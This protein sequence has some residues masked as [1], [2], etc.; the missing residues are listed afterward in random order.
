[1]SIGDKMIA[2]NGGTHHAPLISGAYFDGIDLSR[3]FAYRK[4]V[5]D[6]WRAELQAIEQRRRDRIRQH[7]VSGETVKLT[8][9]NDVILA[10]RAS[11]QFDERPGADRGLVRGFSRASRKRMLVTFARIRHSGP[12]LFLTLTYPD[13]FPKEVDEWHAHFESFRRR[14]ERAMPDA[15]AIWRMELKERKSGEYGQ[16]LTAPH[17]HMM[18]FLPAGS[19]LEELRLHSAEKLNPK[20]HQN[21]SELSDRLEAWSLENWH[22]IAGGSDEHHRVRGAFCAPVENRRHAYWYMS[23]YVSKIDTDN[24][25]VGRRWGRIGRLDMVESISVGLTADESVHLRRLIRRWL[26]SRAATDYAKRLARMNP[27]HGFTVFGLGD[28]WADYRNTLGET[29]IMQMVFHA[30]GLAAAARSPE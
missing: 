15:S 2:Q 25:A 30:M 28:H 20:P 7:Q 26:R 9:Y 1:M 13:I 19:T 4:R 3:L 5:R 21:R 8:V 24:L 16:G 14:F 11:R 23:K 6:N 10:K 29:L 18:V 12:M 22:E 17:Y 27:K